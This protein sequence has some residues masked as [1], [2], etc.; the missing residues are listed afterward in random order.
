MSESERESG[1]IS[2]RMQDVREMIVPEWSDDQTENALRGVPERLAQ[3][4]RKRV[5]AAAAALLVVGAGWL[6]AVSQIDKTTPTT[7]PEVIAK[8]Q[9]E[10]QLRL[11]VVGETTSRPFA[12]SDGSQVLPDPGASVELELAARSATRVKV[13]EGSARFEVESDPERAFIVTAGALEVEVVGTIFVV[14]H[15]QATSEISVHEGLVRTTAR[16]KEVMLRAGESRVVRDELEI[17]DEPKT[18]PPAEAAEKPVEPSPAQPEKVR[19]PAWVEAAES[20]DWQRAATL[21]DRG[22]AP[23]RT[24]A[25][26]LLAADVRRYTGEPAAAIPHLEEVVKRNRKDTFGALAQFR[27]GRI[28][29]RLDRHAD[30]ARAFADVGRMPGSGSVAEDAL[31]REVEALYRA[32]ERQRA[33]ERAHQY[34]ERYPDGFR[35]DFVRRYGG[36]K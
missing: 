36:I 9:P 19:N 34:L 15:R 4:R 24:T 11:G 35:A 10:E 16:G 29:M 20:G 8:A 23:P 14:S 27:K 1:E 2:S 7:A 12:L 21:L 25:E 26:F 32:G 17:E 18:D 33:E 28:L 31:S 30:A 5:V 22:A 13:V 3:R 6:F